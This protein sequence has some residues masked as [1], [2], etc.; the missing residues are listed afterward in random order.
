MLKRSF[1]AGKEDKPSMERKFVEPAEEL[2][3]KTPP[4]VMG[5]SR[6]FLLRAINRRLIVRLARRASIGIPLLGLYFAQ[7]TFRNDLKQSLDP[8]NPHDIR[9]GYKLVTSIDGLD[10]GAQVLMLSGLATT[11]IADP[12]VTTAS[13][14]IPDVMKFAD[15]VSICCAFG[16]TIVG[17][18]LELKKDHDL[19][20]TNFSKN[21]DDAPKQ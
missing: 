12:T 13:I 19:E 18:Y 14:G 17:T 3:R 10:L 15:K 2:I 20:A 4:R 9:K 21:N 5:I 11:L 6:K 7:R 16:S 8:N 1:S